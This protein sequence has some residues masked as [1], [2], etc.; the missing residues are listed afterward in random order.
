MYLELYFRLNN[1]ELHFIFYSLKLCLR[2][3]L[4]LYFVFPNFE[5]Y[6]NGI[7]LNNIILHNTELYFSYQV[8]KVIIIL[9]NLNIVPN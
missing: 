3:Y 4:N 9:D 6:L 7:I 8:I 2:F 1:L 5:L